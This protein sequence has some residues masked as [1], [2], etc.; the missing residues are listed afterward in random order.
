MKKIIIGALIMSLIFCFAGCA[1]KNEPTEVSTEVQTETQTKQTTTK[2]VTTAPASTEKAS[3]KTSQETTQQD[4]SYT[5]L[6]QGYWYRADTNK[7]VVIKFKNDGTAEIS[8]FRNQQ[9]KGGSIAEETTYSGKF[10]IKDGMLK[11]VN[12]DLAES[13]DEYE[14]YSLDNSTLTYLREDPEGSSQ[15]QMTNNID[16]S[17]QFA[18][19]LIED[20]G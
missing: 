10:T 20:E 7:V 1:S 12:T 14:T 17:A 15:V 8:H 18:R 13:E 16:F 19:T 9:L 5:F 2:I 4:T 6:F 3:E 11:L